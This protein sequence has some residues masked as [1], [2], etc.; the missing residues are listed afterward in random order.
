MGKTYM[1]GPEK[2]M[3]TTADNTE[4]TLRL[5]LAL[6]EILLSQNFVYS[7]SVRRNASSKSQKCI[8][9]IKVLTIKT[10]RSQN[11]KEIQPS[12]PI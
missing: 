10:K 3:P 1:G 9:K 2:E 8:Y 7:D 5:R 6:W 12:V 11:E 4:Y